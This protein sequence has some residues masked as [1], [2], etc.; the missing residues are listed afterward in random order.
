MKTNTIIMYLVDNKIVVYNQKIIIE[1]F[2]KN[3]VHNG[4]INKPHEFYHCLENYVKKHKLNKSLFNNNICFLLEPGATNTDK[5]VI[6]NIF[7]KLSF[8]NIEFINISSLLDIKKNKVWILLNDTY[9][10][11]I[12]TNYK[13]KKDYIFIEYKIF[14]N[15]TNLIINHL[16]H[17]TKNKSVIIS[18]ISKKLEEF[19]SK[20][21]TLNNG[22]VYYMNDSI[23]YY[24]NK[25]KNTLS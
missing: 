18:G 16:L 24:I 1:T 4:K 25:I 17:F 6:N 2:E 23:S 13:T 19:S 7:T 10:Y 20:L 12:Y 3:I 9:L 22:K 8:N 21:E 15:N 14:K 11:L 5:E